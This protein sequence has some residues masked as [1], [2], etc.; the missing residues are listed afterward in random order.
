MHKTLPGARRLIITWGILMGLTLIS[1]LSAQ[2]F[3]T[4]W[5]A[6]PLWGA[7]LILISTGFKAHQVLMVYLNLRTSTP[8]WKGAFVG[9]ALLTLALILSGYLAA[10]YQLLG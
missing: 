6:L 3:E 4:G 8:G 10:R 1:M 2:L 5:Q 7:L 9:L